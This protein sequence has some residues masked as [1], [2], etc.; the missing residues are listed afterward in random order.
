MKDQKLYPF[1][2]R[3]H[4]HDIDFRRDRCVNE[5]RRAEDRG[6]IRLVTKLE[7]LRDRLDVIR[8]K[9]AGACGAVVYLTGAEWAL[10]NECVAWAAAAR[11]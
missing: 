8:N 11:R 6:D 4:A 9:M 7:S 1:S 2:T 5:L 10:A 3:K